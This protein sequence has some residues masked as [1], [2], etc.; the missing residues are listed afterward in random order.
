MNKK[1]VEAR[2]LAEARKAGVPIPTGECQ[3]ESPDFRFGSDSGFLGIELSEILRP[4]STNSG[5]MPVQEEAYQRQIVALAEAAY[6][7][8]PIHVSVYFADS[9]GIKRD[10]HAMARALTAFV[11]RKAI[12]AK[13]FASFYDVPDGLSSVA[14]ASDHQPPWWC[15]ASGGYSVTDI[16]EQ[17]ASRIEEKNKLLPQYRANIPTGAP[18]WLLLYSLPGIARGMEL[19]HALLAAV[20]DDCEI[21]NSVVG[22]DALRKDPTEDWRFHFEF[23]R[24]FWFV[25]LLNQF[26]EIKRAVAV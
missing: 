2:V 22:P 21:K 3:G 24:V 6:D 26:V 8:P 20:A 25:S 16:Y 17:L 18:V 14:I 10:K 12:E 1:E 19:P 4:A 7:G 5:I 23:E 11:K 15:G 13:P 9:R